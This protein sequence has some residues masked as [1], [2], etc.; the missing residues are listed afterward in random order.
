MIWLNYIIMFKYFKR[1]SVRKMTLMKNL[2]G[3]KYIG[4]TDLP[5][6]KPYQPCSLGPGQLPRKEGIPAVG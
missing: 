2:D 6:V 4:I 1:K 3:E 5:P